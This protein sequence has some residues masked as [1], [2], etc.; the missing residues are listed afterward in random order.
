MTLNIFFISITIK[1]RR[2]SPK[3]IAHQ[4]MVEK[5]YEQNKDRQASMYRMM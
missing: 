1:K 3:E 2:L 5:L 4:E